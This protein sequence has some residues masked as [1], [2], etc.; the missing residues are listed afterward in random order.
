MNV[1]AGEARS[2]DPRGRANRLELALVA[3]LVAALWM[4]VAWKTFQGYHFVTRAGEIWGVADDVYITADFGRTMAEGG[5]PRWY[6]G[7]PKVEGFTSPV[8]TLVFAALHAVPALTG[9]RLGL[10]VF[11]LNAVLLSA[12]AFMAVSTMSTMIG[13][14][15]GRRSALAFGLPIIGVS[16]FS[17]CYWSGNGFETAL[18][19]L[20]CLCAFRSSVSHEIDE[21]WRVGLVCALA[22]WVRLD[23]ILYCGPPLLLASSG[24]R[25]ARSS[26]RARSVG[27]LIVAGSVAIQT[28]ARVAYYGEALPNTYYLK[29]TGW[30]LEHR[31]FQGWLQNAPPLIPTILALAPLCMVLLP[32]IAAGLRWSLST[33]VCVFVVSLVYSTSM[34]G[35]LSYEAFG[36]DR[37][38]C[39]GAL[40]LAVSLPPLVTAC[41]FRG[42][43]TRMLGFVAVLLL[44]LTPVAIRPDLMRRVR[45]REL[46][47]LADVVSVEK[48]LVG[49][50]TVVLTWVRYG[51][52]LARVTRPE[53]RIAV[54]AAGATVYFSRRSSVDILGKIDKHIARL[55]VPPRPPPDARCWR[56]FPGV[57]HNKEDVRWTFATYDP[58]VS[59]A[60]PPAAETSRYVADGYDNLPLWVRS[61]S[62]YVYWKRLQIGRERFP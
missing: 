39:I 7:A 31:L 43:S 20:L 30:P 37:F 21:L 28:L 57:G 56:G 19:A 12:T 22:M 23:A 54:C 13:A 6:P 51:L 41:G 38:T 49:T 27:M 45:R 8:W 4:F 46:P 29:A 14:S 59:L 58:D 60:P 1:A 40:F 9:K 35:D 26:L 16:G 15:A 42:T 10:S 5:G 33:G 25:G 50:D 18:V 2:T 11:L 3:G 55:P 24:W 44:A 48:S 32:R 34:G 62:R 61:N 52:A 17:I 53:A 47:A 36:Y